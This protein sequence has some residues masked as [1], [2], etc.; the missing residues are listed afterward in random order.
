MNPKVLI[1]VGDATGIPPLFV[2]G[3]P[4]YENFSGLS[5]QPV[6]RETPQKTTV[7]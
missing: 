6:S 3:D 5:Q 1:I 2:T 7:F 4:F